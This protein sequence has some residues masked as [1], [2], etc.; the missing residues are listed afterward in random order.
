MSEA[1]TCRIGT[2][3]TIEEKE[4]LIQKATARHVT[5]AEYIREAATKDLEENE[6]KLCTISQ[7]A[8]LLGINKITVEAMIR[9]GELICYQIRG[10]KRLNKDDIAEY[11]RKSQIKPPKTTQKDKNEYL[12]VQDVASKTGRT[13]Q[14]VQRWI[15]S[16]KLRAHKPGRNY[17]VTPSDFE[18][19]ILLN[20]KNIY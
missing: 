10:V 18:D 16:G 6:D 9:D 7:A 14:T 11:I 1:R 4:A 19:F 3:V 20:D 15:R 13:V 5:L 2:T 12:S 17:M 8:L